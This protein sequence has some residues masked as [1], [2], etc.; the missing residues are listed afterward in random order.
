MARLFG[1]DG[2]RGIA[3]KELTA[4]LAFWLGRAGAYI[5]TNQ[6]S[7][8]RI[9]IGRDTRI[10][11]DMLESA[12]VAGIM[13]VGADAVVAGVLPTPAVAYL[14][15]YYCC[16]AG[17]MISASHNPVQ[18]NGIKFFDGRGFKLPDSAEDEI[19]AI[20]C[21]HSSLPAPEGLGVGR[22]IHMKDPVQDYIDFLTETVSMRFGGMKLVL[23]CANG[24]A[25]A[26]ASRL[27]A[28]LG[29]EVFAYYNLPDGGNINRECGS[30]HPERMC[31][32]VKEHGADAGFAFDGD[33]DRLIACDENGDILDGDHVLAIC[34]T[35]L[36]SQGKLNKE[37]I[38][39]TVMSNM[40]LD[41]ACR[42]HGI[43]LEKTA[44]GDRYVLENM[45]KNGYNLG[46]EKSGHLIFLDHNTTGDGMLSALQLLSAVKAQA[47][48]FSK[49]AKMMV[50]LPQ[51]LMNVTVCNEC[52]AQYRDNPI[53]SQAIAHAEAELAGTG[54][55]LVRP[56]GTEPLLRVMLEGKCE[57][58]LNELGEKIVQAMVQ[59][60][61][62]SV[63]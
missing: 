15:R 50:N 61:G 63:R 42:Q 17:V 32:L 10:S 25:S 52:K 31:E 30:T 12:L 43:R 37:T 5:L 38:V 35:Y 51:V 14:T 2:V 8:P 16:D 41:I 26:I 24:A 56:S 55:V 29:A 6:R 62:G 9:L 58:Q 1:T 27:F 54:R 18:D 23:D 48:S 45:I 59:E 34:G 4:E 36:L 57:K 46:G 19:E 28:A 33:A 53:I 47:I 3:N 13:S 21:A 40:G 11:G 39:G 7:R 22:I 60:L 44:V 49:A 20:V